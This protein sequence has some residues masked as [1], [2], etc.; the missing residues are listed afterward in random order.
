MSCPWESFL[1]ASDEGDMGRFPELQELYAKSEDRSTEQTQKQ[2]DIYLNLLAEGRSLLHNLKDRKE[3]YRPDLYEHLFES[4]LKKVRSSNV[5]GE[6][7]DTE[8][9]DFHP[10]KGGLSLDDVLP[11][12]RIKSIE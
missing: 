9:E 2:L 11:K 12:K 6:S 8:K 4:T 1:E 3:F 5:G 7:G 10:N